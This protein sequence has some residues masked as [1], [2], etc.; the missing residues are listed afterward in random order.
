MV[1]KFPSPPCFLA[2]VYWNKLIKSLVK[3]QTGKIFNRFVSLLWWQ[4]IFLLFLRQFKNNKQLIKRPQAIS[5]GHQ[6]PIKHPPHF[7]FNLLSSLSLTLNFDSLAIGHLISFYAVLQLKIIYLFLSYLVCLLSLGVSILLQLSLHREV[8][9]YNW[10]SNV[11]I[12]FVSN[13]V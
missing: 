11:E 7:L 9:T 12:W 6:H 5:S 4:V 1:L 2:Q 10:A 13:S 8:S 3:R